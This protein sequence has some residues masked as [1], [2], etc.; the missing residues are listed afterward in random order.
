MLLNFELSHPQESKGMGEDTKE[1]SGFKVVDRRPFAADG[2]R[3]EDSREETPKWEAS[4]PPRAPSAAKSRPP[5]EDAGSGYDLRGA[6]V[7]PP[8]SDEEPAEDDP[9][10]A[11]GFST[12]VS[13]LYTTAMFQ[14]G[15]MQGPGGER[16]PADLPN[17]RRTI[18]L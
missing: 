1:Q 13:Y 7:A 14:L 3:R 10:G 12:L 16:I 4:T 5:F 6:R 9:E 2:S 11:S 8:V 15:L 17:G 18:A